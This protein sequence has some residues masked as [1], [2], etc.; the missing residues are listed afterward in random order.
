MINVAQQ[1][2]A[3]SL[4][5]NNFTINQLLKLPLFFDWINCK[6]DKDIHFKMYLAGADD[7][8]ALRFFWNG[9]YEKTTLKLWSYLSRISDVIIDIGA[10]TGAYTL[11]ALAS[12]KKASVYS[13]E[14]HFMNFARLNLN[15]RG[16]FF[17]TERLLMLA[18]GQENATL[19]FS[20]STSLDY[21]STGG[22]IGNRQNAKV[23]N[24]QVVAIDSLFPYE[25]LSK[26]SLIKMDV[27]GHEPS[28]LGGMANAISTSRPIIFLESVVE[29][30]SSL[31][32]S[33]LSEMGY[34]FFT[35]DDISGQ[36]SKVD[37]ISSEIDINGNIAMHRLNRIAVPKDRIDD[38]IYSQGCEFFK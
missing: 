16:N 32:S 7:G 23:T 30:S 27:E 14:P 9:H 8:V 4:I 38:L 34:C 2:R 22:S 33:I 25:I 20:I 35:V 12:N 18:V 13:F 36:I 26:I 31:S 1:A 21:L 10:H 29:K 37:T 15:L 5:E 24:I 3:Q 11:A 17:N 28:C 19:P 6:L